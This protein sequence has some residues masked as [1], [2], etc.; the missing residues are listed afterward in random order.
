MAN[1]RSKYKN[2]YTDKQ[3]SYVSV[4]SILPVLSDSNSEAQSGLWYEGDGQDPNFSHIQY[5]YCDGEEYNIR[6]YPLL[7]EIIGDEYKPDVDQVHNNAY[8]ANSVLSAGSVQ[9]MFWD[10]DKLY[11]EIFNDQGVNSNNKMPYPPGTYFRLTNL[12]VIPTGLFDVN[13][14]YFLVEN[15]Q[16]SITSSTPTITTVYK[17][18]KDNSPLEEFDGTTVNQSTFTIDFTAGGTYPSWKFGKSYNR[19]DLPHVIGTFRVPDYRENKLIGYGNGIEGG[20]TPLVENRTSLT[21]GDVG[22]KWYIPIDRIDDPAVFFTIGDVVTTGYDQVET[23][24][25][26]NLT[27][28]KKYIVGPMEEYFLTRPPEHEHYLIHSRVDENAGRNIGGGVDTLTTCWQNSRGAVLDWVPSSDQGVGQPYG[29]SHGLIGQRLLNPYTATIGNV[30][31]IGEVVDDTAT[32]KEYKIT[33]AP[34][35]D[36]AGVI[37]DG[38]IITVSCNDAHG[39]SDA[40]WITITG[41]GGNWD[42]SYDIETI[43]STDDFTA[44]KVPMPPAGTMP[45]GG[46]VRQ[47]DG[48][49]TPVPYQ[50]SPKAWVIDENATIGKQPIITFIPGSLESAWG[51]EKKL[52]EQ[53]WSFSENLPSSGQPCARLAMELW[54]SGGGGGTTSSNGGDGGDAEVSFSL[55]N[56]SYTIKALGGGGGSAGD[57]GGSGGNGAGWTIPTALLNDDRCVIDT[58]QGQHGGAGG[59]PQQNGGV[60]GGQQYAYGSGG[61]GMGESFSSVSDDVYGP[62]WGGA[63]G[64]T[65]VNSGGTSFANAQYIEYIDIELSGAG[66]GRGNTN[67]NS[68]CGGSAIGGTAHPGMK[69][70]A[71]FNGGANFT[72]TAATQ[73]G[74]G[75]NS[76]SASVEAANGNV[77]H[78]AGTGGGC[79]RGALGNGATGGCG[80]GASGV[81]MNGIAILGAAGGGGGA[82]SGGGDNQHGVVDG[83]YAGGNASGPHLALYAGN[84]IDFDNGLTGGQQGCT[85]GSGGGGGGGCGVDGSGIGGQGGGAGAGHG[86]YGGG[87]GGGTGRSAYRTGTIASCSQSTGSSGAGYVKFTVRTR[88]E[89]YGNSGGGG[90]QGGYLNMVITDP[91]TDLAT[92]VSGTLG[93]PSG[94]G[95]GGG[96]AGYVVVDLLRPQAGTNP[97]T[98]YTTATGRSYTVENYP[99]SKV[100]SL[101]SVGA[102]AA[103]WYD[104]GSANDTHDVKIL[105]P[106]SGTFQVPPATMHDGKVT[107]VLKFSGEGDRHL[108]L[109]PLNTNDWNTA[110]FD[111]IKGDGS[112][113]GDYPEENLM[114]Y[115]KTSAE[116]TRQLLDGLVLTSANNDGNWHTYQYT[117]P[118]DSN[119]RGSGIF[120]DLVQ[121]RTGGGDDN[122][123]NDNYGLGQLVVTYNPT[124]IY[125]FTPSS[126]ASIPGNINSGTTTCGTD[127]GIDVVR[128]EVTANETQILLNDGTFVLSASTPL[129][130]SSAAQ[131]EEP[132]PLV[133]RYMRSKYLIKAF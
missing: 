67:A 128:R 133:T 118:V 66:G 63:Q 51:G 62:Y 132:I 103:I 72:Y 60:G 79:G 10:S 101:P 38:T 129:S 17:V 34:P 93:G 12:G 43:I 7:Y 50:E 35:L 11:F 26:A 84:A 4:G 99:T 77:G 102:G 127:V 87:T 100:Y 126:S 85:A 114:L 113:G 74:D 109:G 78:G 9:K 64:T 29:H 14:N 42:G 23:F 76:Q 124:T 69:L 59:V 130:V 53:G 70:N 112:N 5:L 41:A 68:G 58:R 80:G 75:W 24:V 61:N 36:I 22:G 65:Q 49:F 82:G 96:A 57:S 45:S 3:G 121:D 16:P 110:Y 15:D 117:V 52:P 19:G 120:L 125:E 13:T 28:S 18:V 33:Q 48:I 1:Y 115:Y 47:A 98:G 55:D 6:D 106:V 107:R 44:S 37:S 123:E 27:G 83:C 40:D 90:G 97:I 86:A 21:I 104:A 8:Y 56:V 89:G 71:R 54:A 81:W 131:V 30:G 46:I 119:M 88:Q 108:T 122:D 94:G 31:G 39:L 92:A 91:Y 95:N 32:C 105:N 2:Y 111:I 20:G 116:G 73:G 25:Q